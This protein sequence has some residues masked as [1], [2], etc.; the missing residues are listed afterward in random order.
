MDIE[1]EILEIK[2]RNNR[3][4]Q[5]KAWE[6]SWTRRIFIAAVTYVFAAAWLS[7]INEPSLWWK[8]FVPV[9]GYLFSTFSLPQIKKWWEK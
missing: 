7:L 6:L 5:D 1:Q 9:A 2:T 8:A 3:V 4:G